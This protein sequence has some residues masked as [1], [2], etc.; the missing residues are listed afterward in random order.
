[1]LTA[2]GVKNQHEAIA[3]D[4]TRPRK[5]DRQ[6]KANGHSRVHSIAATAQYVR[7]DFGCHCILRH[8]HTL[9]ANDGRMDAWIFEQLLFLGKD[10][11]CRKGEHRQ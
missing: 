10:G 6:G 7:A 11:G 4:I 9:F 5:C 8:H 1:L 3:T 2:F